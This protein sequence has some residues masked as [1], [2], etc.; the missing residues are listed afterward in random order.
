M[1]QSATETAGDPDAGSGQRAHCAGHRGKVPRADWQVKPHCR[2]SEVAN[3]P[4]A[5]AAGSVRRDRPRPRG[6]AE[7]V[8]GNR[9]VFDK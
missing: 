6:I 9:G 8:Y 5:D 7:I 1:P 4:W 3:G 2:P